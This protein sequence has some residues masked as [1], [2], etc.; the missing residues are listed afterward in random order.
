MILKRTYGIAVLTYTSVSLNQC[1][2]PYT[3][4]YLDHQYAQKCIKFPD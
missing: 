2:Q 1:L 4:H 3:S